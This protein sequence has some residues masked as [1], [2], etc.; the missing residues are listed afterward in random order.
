MTTSLVA[1]F[2]RAAL[3]SV[4]LAIQI[5]HY[6]KQYT[7]LVQEFVPASS[8]V[9]E[10][11]PGLLG[12][13]IATETGALLA[14]WV[15]VPL[16]QIGASRAGLTLKLT[17]S[18]W[19]D[20]IGIGRDFEG[21]RPFG[22]TVDATLAD[23]QSAFGEPNRR[24]GGAPGWRLLDAHRA[25][26]TLFL[27]GHEGAQGLFRSAIVLM[28]D[29]DETIRWESQMRREGP[30]SGVV[31]VGIDAAWR[32]LRDDPE[33]LKGRR[34]VE[35]G[36]LGETVWWHSTQPL[37]YIIPGRVRESASYEVFKTRSVEYTLRMRPSGT[38]R[39]L[40][41]ELMEFAPT[42]ELILGREWQH[43]PQM[44]ADGQLTGLEWAP[45]EAAQERSQRGPR[46]RLDVRSAEGI[47][48]LVLTLSR[49]LD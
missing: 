11:W 28:A 7:K 37:L 24:E 1:N 21:A 4:T 20:R 38:D 43:E 19:I 6:T 26:M 33:A 47:E 13:D 2:E 5:N 30:P 12:E 9:S 25:P 15:G 27:G 8:F 23:V 44:G 10:A 32:T 22:L 41:T 18:R 36:I 49:P 45:K 42:V 40:A 46:L 31:A 17:D 34:V 48:E 29:R 35:R 3:R 39:P 14:A 16:G